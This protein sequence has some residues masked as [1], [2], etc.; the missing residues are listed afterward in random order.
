MFVIFAYFI[1]S[2]ACNSMMQPD[3]SEDVSA[4]EMRLFWGVIHCKIPK[5]ERNF[6]HLCPKNFK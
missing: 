1:Y 5:F 6:S 4:N 3:F 2:K